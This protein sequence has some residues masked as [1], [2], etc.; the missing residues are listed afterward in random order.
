M[1]GR[2]LSRFKHEDGTCSSALAVS[3]G[4]NYLAVGAESGAVSLFDAHNLPQEE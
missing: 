4:S 1:H 3:R 2:C